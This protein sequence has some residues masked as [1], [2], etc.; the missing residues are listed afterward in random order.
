L[1][2][3]VSKNQTLVADLAHERA[4]AD[5]IRALRRAKRGPRVIRRRL[6]QAGFTPRGKVFHRT[7]IER[8]LRVVDDEIKAEAWLSS[9]DGR[10]ALA[11]TGN[12]E[13]VRIAREGSPRE[14]AS[15][16]R[17][18]V[19]LERQRNARAQKGAVPA[20]LSPAG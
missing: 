16:A 7:S 12:S 13:L 2:Q 17:D 8:A 11:S 10:A 20:F 5:G 4:V 18:A 3:D 19:R 9:L 15:L 14:F 6:E 1:L